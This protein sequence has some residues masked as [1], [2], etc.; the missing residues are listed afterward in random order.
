[1]QTGVF[2]TAFIS[3][4]VSVCAVSLLG[5]GDDTAALLAKH[6]AFMG[7]AY[8]DGSLGS[9]RETLV[10]PAASPKPDS[11]PAAAPKP[12][13][14][15]DPLGPRAGRMTIARRQLLYRE[16]AW[17]YERPIRDEGFTGS[18]VWVASEN[19]FTERMRGHGAAMSLTT[20][21]IDAEAFGEVPAAL[22]SPVTFDGKKASV[23]RITPNQGVAADL[24]FGDDGALLGYTL[25]PDDPDERQTVHFVAYGEFQAHKRY[26]KALRFGDSARTYEVTDFQPNANVSEADLHPPASRATWTF[27]EP[28]SVPVTIRRST[29][30]GSA[31]FVDLSVNGHVGHFLVDSG[32]GGTILSDH[33]AQIAGVTEVGRSAFS[34]VNGGVIAATTV[35]IDTIKIGGNTLHDLIAERAPPV[36]AGQREDTTTDGIIGFDLFADALVDVNLGSRTLTVLDP[37]ENQPVV[38]PGAY[39]FQLDL[40]D[41]HAGVPLKLQDEV[42]PSVW[43]D[44]GNAFFVV[45]PHAIESRHVATVTDR[46]FFYGVDGQGQYPANCVRFN[47]IQI[48]PYRY[49]HALS[50]FAPNEAFGKS[51]G[52]IGFDFLKHSNWTFDYPHGQ[53][54][55]TPNGD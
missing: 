22:R 15:P 36:A 3:A 39:A 37:K 11:T 51:R 25:D 38:K 41:F 33:F 29:Y 40:S 27:G 55:L 14:S 54:V 48:G 5:V 31:V 23:V 32:A 26:V 47:E 28:H 30:V 53:L 10:L 42:L 2:R 43:L 1:M 34:G 49:Q 44:T 46:T 18:L 17:A 13:R 19:G 7:W 45:L 9:L 6:K 24:F 16:T 8:G 21:I 12:G 4:C 35:K 52:L 50:C 20:D